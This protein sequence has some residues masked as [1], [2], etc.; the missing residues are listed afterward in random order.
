MKLYKKIIGYKNS[1]SDTVSINNSQFVSKVKEPLL[2]QIE[3]Q[4]ALSYLKSK[5][6]L[7]YKNWIIKI[8]NGKNHNIEVAR[9]THAFNGNKNVG[10]QRS[11]YW[12]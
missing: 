1:L 6:T 12:Y 11:I 4:I 3:A 9:I 2:S 7:S 8:N 5:D 10:C